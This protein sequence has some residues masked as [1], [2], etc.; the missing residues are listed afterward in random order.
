[1]ALTVRTADLLADYRA[2]TDRTTVAERLV[3]TGV[4][5]LDVYNISGVFTEAGRS[6]IAGR[7]EARE[8]E[9]STVVIFARSEDCTWAPM[10]GAARLTLQDPFV[11]HH[12]G[13]RYL[14]GVEIAEAIVD[15]QPGLK[16][17]T[18]VVDHRDLA[19]PV[20]A[21]E[22]PWGMKDLRFVDLADG[23]LGVLT[24]PQGGADGRG[25]IGFTSVDSLAALTVAEIDAAPRLE[26]LFD[27][28]E[29][30]GV[31]HA[32]LMADGRI[33]LLGHIAAFDDDGG[34]HYYPMTFSLDPTTLDYTAPRVLFERADLPAGE[35]KRPDLVD[36]IFPGWVDVAAPRPTVYCGVGDAEAYRVELPRL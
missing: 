1:M 18:M 4:E 35:S 21:F 27:P 19:A 14:G 33:G 31:N 17:R 9:N 36:V 34:R 24:R 3:F 7:V 10:E 20:V 32:W 6:F 28:A 29:W 8:S 5:G 26:D 23:R 11:F 12:A 13:V 2:G 25:R 22:G 30:G 15:G 16:W